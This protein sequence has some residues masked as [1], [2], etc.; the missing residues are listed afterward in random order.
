MLCSVAAGSERSKR[1]GFIIAFLSPAI[2]LYGGFVIYPL[3]QA[4]QLSFYR[5]RGVSVRK[6]FV[7]TDNF[8]G[9]VHDNVFWKALENNL[10]L[11]VFGGAFIIVLS[12]AIAHGM[13]SHSV[14]SRVLRRIYLFPQVISMVVVAILWM[15]MFN[16]SYG[17][18]TALM[19]AAG[20]K[21]LSV[22]ILGDPRT[23]LPAVAV[24]FVWYA[25]GFYI[26]LF[27]AGLKGIPEEVTEAASLDGSTGMHRFWKITWPM[28]W[29]IKRI[30]VIYIVINVMNV[31]ALVYIMTDG[32][33]DSASEVMLT[34]LYR[35]GFRDSQFGQATV[36]AVANFIVAM[37]LA[38][39]VALLLRK[40]PTKGRAQ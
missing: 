21:S 34:Y 19:K 20:L 2:L 10:W 24:A 5:W 11:M 39:V 8:V 32:G 31:F 17:P 37:A 26:M 36:L 30:A 4:F 27:S 14:M 12:I 23:A 33:P 15:F 25:L 29:S 38:G 13:Q 9:L 22:A 6:T 16:P 40:D 35:T 1:A 7:G 28:L 3:I 18:A